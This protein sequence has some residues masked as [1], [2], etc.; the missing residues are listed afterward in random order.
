MEVALIL[1]Q[2]VVH[3]RTGRRFSRS[4]LLKTRLGFFGISALVQKYLR[5]IATPLG[6][7]S[8]I[9][10]SAKASSIKMEVDD[11]I[12]LDRDRTTILS[13]GIEAPCP[14]RF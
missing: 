12:H 13:C 10:S 3:T 4:T 11:N 2:H 14:H 5:P 9:S 1:A 7:S 6:R 8:L